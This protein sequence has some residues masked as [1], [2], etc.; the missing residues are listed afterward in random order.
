MEP[1][2]LSLR[3][4]QGL[5]SREQCTLLGPSEYNFP[6]IG[7]YHASLRTPFAEAGSMPSSGKK[8]LNERV[9]ANSLIDNRMRATW[10][11]SRRSV[12]VSAVEDNR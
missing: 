10:P 9:I 5:I 1:S 2:N 3:S 12:L 6:Q 11:K 4:L 7:G 8:N